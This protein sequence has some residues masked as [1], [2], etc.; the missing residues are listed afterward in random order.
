M[1]R[2][3]NEKIRLSPLT[4]KKS[5]SNGRHSGCLQSDS[6]FVRLLNSGRPPP[7]ARPLRGSGARGA[8]IFS[9]DFQQQLLQQ[10]AAQQHPAAQPA[11]ATTVPQG[12]QPHT[13]QYTAQSLPSAFTPQHQTHTQHHG[14]AAP[15]PPGPPP[16]PWGLTAAA[17]PHAS[18]GGPPFGAPPPAAATLPTRVAA[19]LTGTATHEWAQH[20]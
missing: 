5:R 4:A 6:R 3:E 7:R 11:R 16:H 13:Q 15:P 10:Q 20:L 14:Q 9:R 1:A 18:L 12:G 8:I 2:H 19:L 17:T